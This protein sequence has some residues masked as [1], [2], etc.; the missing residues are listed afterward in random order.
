MKRAIVC[1]LFFVLNCGLGLAQNRSA[2]PEIEWV[3][4]DS[5]SFQDYY[6]NPKRLLETSTGT[7]KA[8][9]IIELNAD[10]PDSLQEL[11]NYRK[12]RG[13]EIS[14]YSEFS[15]SLR[16]YE[17]DCKNRRLRITAVVDYNKRGSAL[18]S[19]ELESGNWANLSPDSLAD[20]LASTVCLYSNKN[21]VQ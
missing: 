4:V 2:A 8:S 1:L 14:G 3:Y 17:V 10:N 15:H 12:K 21:G 19:L 11:F 13:F 16:V 20:S 7:L 9:V 18:E 5:T 6:W